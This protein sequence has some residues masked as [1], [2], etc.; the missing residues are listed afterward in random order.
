MRA[1]SSDVMAVLNT[2]ISGLGGAC[3]PDSSRSYTVLTSVPLAIPSNNESTLAVEP[4][5]TYRIIQGETHHFASYGI[6]DQAAGPDG[7]A[8]LVYNT[9]SSK[10][11]GIYMFGDVLQFTSD[12]NGS[13]GLRAFAT[14]TDA[15]AYMLTSEFQNIQK[16]I[17]SFKALG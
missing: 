8:C 5:F 9:V 17:T 7:K 4:R 3:Q 14:I 15:R 11:L 1:A 12:P 10:K 16:M 13:P 2:H 6:T